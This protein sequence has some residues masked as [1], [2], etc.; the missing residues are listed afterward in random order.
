[1]KNI[2]LSLAALL[3]LSSCG[4]NSIQGLDED[5]AAA[6]AEIQNQY[7][8]RADLVPQLIKVVDGVK[9]YESKTLKE[10]VDARTQ[11]G[12]IQMNA[13]DLND[14]EKMKAF[15]KAQ[16]Q[17]GSALS[18]LL[19]TVERYPDLKATQ[20]FRDLQTQ[21]EGTEN[22]IAVARKR[23]IETVSAYNKKVRYFPSNLTAKYLLGAEVKQ[24]LLPDEAEKVEKVP[25][26]KF[27]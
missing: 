21:L 14:S 12:K 2:F 16:N 17:L 20:N 4:Y 15:Q 27:D 11:V 19:M 6:W 1:M 22:R 18:R 26:I 3:L 9:N 10:V 25:D 24:Q 8:R 13:S 23:Y 7:K 5:V